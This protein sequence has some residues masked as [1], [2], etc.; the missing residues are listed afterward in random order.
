[1][2]STPPLKAEDLVKQSNIKKK[3][4]GDSIKPASV[5]RLLQIMKERERLFLRCAGFRE[6]F[7]RQPS[8]LEFYGPPPKPPKTERQR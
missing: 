2:S 3:L 5:K 4:Q 1:M 7:G 6:A 8:S